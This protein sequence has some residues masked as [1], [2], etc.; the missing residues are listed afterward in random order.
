MQQDMPNGAGI[1]YQKNERG[2]FEFEPMVSGGTWSYECI[3]WLSYMKTQSPFRTPKRQIRIRH[4]LNGGEVEVRCENRRYKVDGYAEIDGIKHFL[5]F[6]GCRFH[7]HN[8]YTSLSSNVC[9][10]DDAQ[11]NADLKRLGCFIQT[12]ECDW[13]KLK[14]TVEF[15]NSVSRFFARRNITE[16]EILNAV[17]NGSFFGIIR[18]DIS[19]PQSVV[20][21]FNQVN[22]PPIF[23]HVAVEEDMLAPRMLSILKTQGV[24]FPLKKQLTLAFNREQY[25][26]T[27]ELA[28]FYV[29]KGMILSNLT[30]AV[31]YTRSKPLKTFVDTVTEK[32]KQA[33]RTGDKNLQN[34]WKL[35]SNSCYGRLS[36][37]LLKRRQYTYKPT[38]DAPV[39]DENPFITAVAPVTGE[40]NTAYVEVTR[41]KKTT[42]DKI[43]G[44]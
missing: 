40:F 13:L 26:L 3:S 20:D 7:K 29:K 12:F 41:K 1:C 42:T 14:Q 43:P 30:L 35:V 8:C 38:K 33:T 18:V 9:N 24:K 17:N 15:T 36:L 25:V 21:Y 6:D 27:S 37:N 4:A 34:T 44:T 19:S 2:L 22:F 16:M 32:R 31:E 11:R 28:R 23:T 39:V 5:E 10:K